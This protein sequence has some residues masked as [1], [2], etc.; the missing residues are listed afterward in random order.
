[1]ARTHGLSSRTSEEVAIDTKRLKSVLTKE[2]KG[3][4][5]LYGHLLPYVLDPALA[6]R[7]VVLRCEPSVLKARLQH[8]GYPREKVIENVE[9]ELIG[10]VSADAYQA[11]G[12]GKTFEFDTSQTSPAAAVSSLAALLR[13]PE[14]P[15]RI[16]WT[17]AYDSGLKLRSLLS[18]GAG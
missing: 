17:T 3:P 11:F 18:A 7:V 15:Q 2:L 5:V 1:M 10:V 14:G 13:R 8:R 12:D 16:D 6:S 9:A 4:V